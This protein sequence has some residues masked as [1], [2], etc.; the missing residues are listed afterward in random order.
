LYK[1][2]PIFTYE[3]IFKFLYPEL[4]FIPSRPIGATLKNIE[5]CFFRQYRIGCE[6]YDINY[7]KMYEY[8]PE[9]LNKKLSPK[10]LYLIYHN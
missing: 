4:E 7:N 1:N 3:G 9:T 8:Y 10:I 5:Y 2:Q 6:V